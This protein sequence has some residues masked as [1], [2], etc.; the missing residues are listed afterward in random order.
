MKDATAIVFEGEQ[1]R[2][3]GVR[4]KVPTRVGPL[5][6]T[7]FISVEEWTEEKT[8]GVHRRGR[9]GGWGRFELSPRPD[10]TLLALTECLDFPWYM[11]G[12]VAG[13]FARPVLRRV[14]RSN[15]L[16]FG[17]WVKAQS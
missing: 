1:R 15:L 8:I 9:I 16:N 4:M 11:G 2:G 10:G 12:P 14:F 6:V 7:D 3:V 13:W 17:D 5:R